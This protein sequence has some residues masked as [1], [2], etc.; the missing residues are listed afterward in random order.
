MSPTRDLALA[1]EASS[2]VASP[3]WTVTNLVRLGCFSPAMTA[4][5]NGIVIRIA[6][7]DVSE[8]SRATQG[9]KIM[10]IEEDTKIIS[11]AKVIKEDT[12]E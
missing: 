6:V 10:K 3:A 12:V 7:K 9:V 8:L 2:R 5:V 11:M 4:R 1:R